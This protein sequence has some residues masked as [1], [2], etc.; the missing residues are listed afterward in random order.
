MYFYCS[1][2]GS[3]PVA[4]GALRGRAGGAAIG[5]ASLLRRHGVLRLAI[6]PTTDPGGQPSPTGP[7]REEDDDEP[8]RGLLRGRTL[9]QGAGE[10]RGVMRG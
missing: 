7:R 10:G 4:S 5:C 1:V 8:E 9:A 2:V 6:P 3:G